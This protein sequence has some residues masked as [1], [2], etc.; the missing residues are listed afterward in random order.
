MTTDDEFNTLLRDSLDDFLCDRPKNG[1][2]TTDP[3]PFD[4]ALWQSMAELGWLGLALPESLNG[5]GLGLAEAALVAERMGY[6]LSPAPYVPLAL[7]PSVLLSACADKSRTGDLAG[8]LVSGER[9]VSLAWQEK[10]G[11]LAPATGTTC[12]DGRLSGR[13]CF[14]ADVQADTTLLVWAHDHR[15]EPLIAAVPANAEGVT[16]EAAPAGNGELATVTFEGAAIIDNSPLCSGDR[17]ARALHLALD[18]GRIALSAQLDGLSRSCLAATIDYLGD[19]QQ[20]G[21]ALSAF[22]ALRHRCADLHIDNELARASWQ[23]AL[24]C[25]LDAPDTD[26]TRAAISAAK[27]RCADTALKVVREAIQMHGAMGFVEEGGMGRYLRMALRGAAWLGNGSQHRR[28]FTAT[29]LQWHPNRQGDGAHPQNLSV[30]PGEDLNQLSDEEFRLRFRAFLEA[31]YP[32][33]MRQDYVRP[34]RRMNGAQAREWLKL[35][36]RHGW[37]APEWPREHGGLGLSFR[38]QLIYNEEQERIGVA[39]LIDNGVTQLGPT[40]MKYGTDDQ[41]ARY[42]PRILACEDYWAQGYSE[43]NAGSDLASLGTRAVRDGEHFIV[44]GQKIWTTLAMEAT[45]MY[46]LVRTGNYEKKQQGISFLLLELDQPGVD[47]RPIRHIA[48]EEELCEVFF[49]DV[50]VP[51]ENLVGPLDDGWTVAKALLG[52]ERIWLASPNLADK[53]MMLAQK[54]VRELGRESDQG[55]RDR[56]G[57]LLADLHD[58]RQWYNAICRRAEA[59]ETI[60]AEASALKVYITE[61]TQRITEFNLDIGEDCGAL[62]G[63]VDLDGTTTDLYWQLAMSRPGTIYAGC[64]EV[65]RDILAKAVLRMPR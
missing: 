38:K 26:Q 47:I 30:E 63:E 61:L 6:W 23:H 59:G 22:Q 19:R 10:A 42:L 60:G 13:K 29:R 35:V 7:M 28:R 49:T 51:V 65:Q 24:S 17:A 2:G 45:H 57:Q 14:V 44:N 48:G 16:V 12:I 41:K 4:R 9:L 55:V 25:H 34:F 18:A 11:Q 31:H 54:L 58:Y 1:H 62:T 50:R 8:S 3:A 40:L 15:D 21:K 27:A 5:A 36:H 43:P 52:H 56:L 20:F 33:T 37:R 64:N 39:R 53:A 32:K 46:A